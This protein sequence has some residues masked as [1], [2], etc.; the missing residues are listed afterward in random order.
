MVKTRVMRLREIE[1][2]DARDQ[3]AFCAFHSFLVEVQTNTSYY[4]RRM[5]N[6]NVKIRIAGS[7]C[8]PQWVLV[9]EELCR[10]RRMV[11]PEA[12]AEGRVV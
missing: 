6:N 1:G 11:F 8:R 2:R 12:E 9:C 4:M 7:F 5:L 3:I 10:S